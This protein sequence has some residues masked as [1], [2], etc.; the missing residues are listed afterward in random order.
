VMLS[1]VAE[2]LYWMGR[3]VERA[4]DTS[5][6]L[7]VQ[8]HALLEDPWGDEDRACRDLLRTMGIDD[9][10][11][12]LDIAV[13]TQRLAFSRSDT[14]SI[15]GALTAAREN[16]RGIRETLS[17]E[18]WECLNATY[19]EL[20]QHETASTRL[21]PGRFLRYVRERSATVAG[22][23]EGTMPQDDGWRFL[24]L[25]RS[26]ERVD[27]TARL[28]SV[29]LHRPSPSWVPL[30]KCCSAYEAYL[31]T[32]RGAPEA[33]R[34]LEFLLLDRL[35]PRS[36]FAAL[37]QAELCLAALEPAVGRVG[38]QDEARRRLGRM[39]TDLEFHQPA[40]LVAGLPAVLD[41]L[42]G[43]CAEVG[44]LLAEKHFHSGQTSSWA[45]EAG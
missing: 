16:A 39:R 26:L 43:T 19:H 11:G 4:E 41:D 42:Q 18:V 28:L 22:L 37:S 15:T 40:E 21:G 8:L 44:L 25:G 27:M 12:P 3:Y 36:V 9:L 23:I 24:M 6:L 33:G 5:R 10:S 45:V 31:R 32:Y 13:T 17:S 34:V 38:V 2:A 30:L 14:S 29:G 1:R 7:D 20:G 35:F